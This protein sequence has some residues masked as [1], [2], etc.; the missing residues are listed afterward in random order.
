MSARNFS[1]IQNRG[2]SGGAEG[3]A[4]FMLPT[5]EIALPFEGVFRRAA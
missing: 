1:V 3:A 4:R 5:P 2:G